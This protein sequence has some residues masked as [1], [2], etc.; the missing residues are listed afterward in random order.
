MQENLRDVDTSKPFIQHFELKQPIVNE[1]MY[2]ALCKMVIDLLPAS[3]LSHFENTIR[4][5]KSKDFAP[6]SHPS[7]WLGNLS[8]DTAVYK[9]PM[10]D[11]FINN[12]NLKQQAPYCT[13]IIWIYDIAYL[14]VMPLVDVDAGQY[15]Y[16]NQLAAHLELM[17]EWAGLEHWQQ[18]NTGN[19]RLSIPWVNWLVDV[20]LKN[21]HIL[22]ET[23]PVFGK[24]QNIRKN[25]QGIQMPDVLPEDLSMVNIEKIEFK[26]FYNGPKCDTD[27]MD[28][29]LHV[30][31]PLYVLNL[32]KG[33]VKVVLKIEAND[34]T[35]KVAY[36]KEFFAVNLHVNRF[37]EFVLFEDND[38]ETTFVFHYQLRDFLF[39]YALTMVEHEMLKLRKGSQFEKCTLERISELRERLIEGSVYIIPFDN[40]KY[41]RIPDSMIHGIAYD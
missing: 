3:E 26:S 25:V 33:Q 17:K 34:T 19:Y 29:T 22:S 41:M 2:K 14:F 1:Q 38:P 6:D 7:I 12:R 16:D 27:L 15:K 23:D 20:S 30:T 40:K 8:T 37:C 28:I 11:I 31:E 10:L 18:Q 5:I 32:K 21:V 24:C 13:A 39:D 35:D 9:Q 36:F 4:W